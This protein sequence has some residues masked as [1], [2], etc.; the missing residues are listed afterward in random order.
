MTSEAAIRAAEGRVHD[1]EN[2]LLRERIDLA[3][4]KVEDPEALALVRDMVLFL[5][6]HRRPS[7][8]RMRMTTSTRPSTPDGA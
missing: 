5:A 8:I 6:P 1:A 4:L 3:A 2:Q 7:S